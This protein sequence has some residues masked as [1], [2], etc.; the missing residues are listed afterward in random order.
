[1]DTPLRRLQ[2]MRDIGGGFTADKTT[3]LNDKRTLRLLSQPTYRYQAG[4]P[5]IID[6][7][8]FAFVEG[9]DP[10]VF[11]CLEAR[12]ENGTSTWHYGLARMNSL[13]VSGS[14]QGKQVWVA[15]TLAPRDTYNRKDLPYTALM[16]K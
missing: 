6:G 10:E 9:T 4:D 14:Y 1:A 3:R 7:A 5:E 12:Q 11:L 8:L 2:Q 13:R 15:D 16:I